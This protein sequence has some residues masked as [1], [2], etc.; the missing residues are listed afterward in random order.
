MEDHCQA[1][2]N[3]THVFLAGGYNRDTSFNTADA[4]ILNVETEEF[5]IMPLLSGPLYWHL[6]GVINNPDFGQEIVVFQNFES[7]I[8][9]VRDQV[10]RPGPS[11]NL[12]YQTSVAQQESN[13]EIVGGYPDQYSPVTVFDEINYQFVELETALRLAREDHVMIAVPDEAVNC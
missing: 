6:C 2:I 3:S 7:E 11:N 9:N 4:Y 10:W 12:G 5:Q 8:F 13:F 1:T